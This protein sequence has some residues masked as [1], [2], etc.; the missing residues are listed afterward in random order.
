MSEKE[1]PSLGDWLRE[2]RIG[3][4]ASLRSVASA[5]EI[6]P[7]YLSD[8]ENNHRTPAEEVLRRLTAYLELDFEQGMA[9]AGR[10]GDQTHQYLRRQPAAVKLLR[11]VSAAD[12]SAQDLEEISRLIAQKFEK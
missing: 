5:M 6:T 12:L 4:G 8:I 1:A 2:A 3:R 9:L 7:S 11:Q 10:F